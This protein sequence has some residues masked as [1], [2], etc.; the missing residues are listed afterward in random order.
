VAFYLEF[1]KSLFI[2]GWPLIL[3][4][5][6]SC[7]IFDLCG[8]QTSLDLRPFL[9]FFQN[10]D[11]CLVGHR[12]F[13]VSGIVGRRFLFLESFIDF[14]DRDF[15]YLL[16]IS[17]CLCIFVECKRLQ[18]LACGLFSLFYKLPSACFPWKWIDVE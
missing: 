17:A 16:Q 5:R 9:G 1:F 3:L 2:F 13:E 8:L 4:Y 12:F 7:T 14:G 11:F 10:V 6:R 18:V 15:L